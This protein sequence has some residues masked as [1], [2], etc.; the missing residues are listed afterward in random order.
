MGYVQVVLAVD[1][2]QVVLAVGYVQ[3]VLAVGYV[4]VVSSEP[5]LPYVRPL[6]ASHC[7]V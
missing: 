1:Y 3:D 7:T 4:Q 2:D 6:S 5:S